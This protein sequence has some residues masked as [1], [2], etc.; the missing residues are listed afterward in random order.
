[1]PWRTS[2]NKIDCGIFAMR[3]LETYMGLD[4]WDCGFSVK[5]VAQKDQI[6]ELRMKFLCKI[7]LSEVNEARTSLIEDATKFQQ[8]RTEDKDEM[9][10]NLEDKIKERQSAFV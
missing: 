8:M 5:E 3:H 4:K 7:L 1:M 10:K 9:L 6:Y 2:D